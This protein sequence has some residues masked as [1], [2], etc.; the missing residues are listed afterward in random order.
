MLKIE[1]D[2]NMFEIT[3]EVAFFSRFNAFLALTCL[4]SFKLGLFE[5]KIGTNTI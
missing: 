2:S 1:N 4:K 5:M 3:C